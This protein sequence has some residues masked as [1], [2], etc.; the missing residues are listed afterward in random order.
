MPVRLPWTSRTSR[1]C[2]PSMAPT[3]RLPPRSITKH[4]VTAR[5][6]SDPDALDQVVR[7]DL[8]LARPAGVVH[9]GPV[10]SV[11]AGWVAAVGVAVSGLH[12]RLDTSAIEVAAHHPHPLAIRTPIPWGSNQAGRDT[13]IG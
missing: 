13:P 9:R 1:Q 2:D 10:H 7:H 6:E 3:W 8:R 4:P 12:Q 5:A 11:A